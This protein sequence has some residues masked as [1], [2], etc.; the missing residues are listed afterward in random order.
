MSQEVRVAFAGHNRP[1]DLRDQTTI[2]AALR[3]TVDLICAAG[4]ERAVLTTGLAEGADSLA[5]KVWSERGLGP[6]HA[7]L[8]FLTEEPGAEQ[9][10]VAARRTVLDG[11]A[12]E[13]K[14][15]SPHLVQTRWLI[16]DA[17]LLIVV[18]NGE[19]ARAPAAHRM[20]FASP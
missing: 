10:D 9:P 18:W 3:R 6:V 19:V 8:P 17:D 7:V 13:A 4:V 12:I 5:V 2:E 15:R 11:A 16:E 1:E 20:R 14:G